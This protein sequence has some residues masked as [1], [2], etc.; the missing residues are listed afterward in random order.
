MKEIIKWIEENRTLLLN[1]NEISQ[2]TI[3]FYED[4]IKECE[5]EIEHFKNTIKENTIQ[6][7]MLQLF[8]D[9][10]ISEENAEP[11]EISEEY[12]HYKEYNDYNEYN[13][14]NYNI[15]IKENELSS[16][17][18]NEEYYNNLINDLCE[19]VE[20]ISTK[21]TGYIFTVED[22][23]NDCKYNIVYE[24]SE[25]N[26]KYGFFLKKDNGLERVE[27]FNSDKEMFVNYIKTIFPLRFIR[28]VTTNN[29]T[30]YIINDLCT[31]IK[32]IPLNDSCYL[33][34]NTTNSNNF[35]IIYEYDSNVDKNIISLYEVLEDSERIIGEWCSKELAIDYVKNNLKDSI[36][37]K[38]KN[39]E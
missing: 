27:C 8:F 5:E 22:T 38:L 14:P 3:N 37:L 10:V 13:T 7:H 28:E 20:L 23:L 17:K 11:T 19:G 9:K 24:F 39:C 32:E 31:A 33:Y 16:E 29:N 6:L 35:R 12:N 34:P 25:D 15:N 21:E 26:G 36:E 18:G 1:S 4:K 2:T 30:D